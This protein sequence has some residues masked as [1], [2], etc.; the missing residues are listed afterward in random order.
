VQGLILAQLRQ[1]AA[2]TQ[3]LAA[4]IGLTANT[5]GA[6]LRGMQG[7]GEVHSRLLAGETGTRLWMLPGAVAA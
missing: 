5:M 1:G 4:S 7:R 3:V 2:T 6:I